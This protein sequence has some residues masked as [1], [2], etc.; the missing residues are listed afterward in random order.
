M[1]NNN[2]LA[3]KHYNRMK[4]FLKYDIDERDIE[5]QKIILSQVIKAAHDMLEQLETK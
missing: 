5:E 1:K 3:I 2:D 4:G